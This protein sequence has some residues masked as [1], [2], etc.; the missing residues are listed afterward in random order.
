MAA[1]ERKLMQIGFAALMARKLAP[2]KQYLYEKIGEGGFV[3]EPVLRNN[4]A[5]LDDYEYM[6]KKYYSQIVY[7]AAQAG[8]LDTSIEESNIDIKAARRLWAGRSGTGWQGTGKGGYM[9]SLDPGVGNPVRNEVDELLHMY[10]KYQGDKTQQLTQLSHEATYDLF[11]K[12]AEHSRKNNP[13]PSDMAFTNYVPSPKDMGIGSE[14]EL[15]WY[16]LP[17]TSGDVPP[18]NATPSEKK[19]WLTKALRQLPIQKWNN[20]KLKTQ[21]YTSYGKA[22]ADF[23][24][25]L[26]NS[27]HLEGDDYR[28]LT[29]LDSRGPRL[30]TTVGTGLDKT[31]VEVAE[32]SESF[33][34]TDAGMDRYLPDIEPDKPVIRK[35]PSLSGYDKSDQHIIMP[36]TYELG[37]APFGGEG[38]ALADTGIGIGADPQATV[39]K[40]LLTTIF[41]K[42][43]IE[44]IFPDS[45]TEYQKMRRNELNKYLMN[46][47]TGEGGK[48]LNQ[49]ERDEAAVAL[50]N[51]HE[52]KQFL[53]WMEN[54]VNMELEELN[55]LTA[56][57][58]AGKDWFKEDY[59]EFASHGK[60]A[61]GQLTLSDVSPGLKLSL[62]GYTPKKKMIYGP[63]GPIST[64]H[65]YLA[66]Q[67]GWGKAI[68]GQVQ[69]GG[70]LRGYD[71]K[72]EI[73]D[74]FLGDFEIFGEEYG[75]KA[76]QI[77]SWIKNPQGDDVTQWE[78]EHGKW[79]FK[80][81]DKLSRGKDIYFPLKTPEGEPGLVKI[82]VRATV[83][84]DNRTSPISKK[85]YGVT[86]ATRP[87][88]THVK[89]TLSDVQYIKDIKHTV[90][91][92]E[93]KWFRHAEG[94]IAWNAYISSLY[95]HGAG[96]IYQGGALMVHSGVGAQMFM[97]DR[98][99]AN[100]VGFFTS[101]ISTGDFAEKL[102]EL[103]DIGAKSWFKEADGFGAYFDLS[104]MAGG[105]FK[106]WAQVWNGESSKIER[107]INKKIQTKWALWL[108]QYAGGGATAP[109]PR[110]AKS[111][112][113]PI[114]LGPFVHSTKFLGQAQSAT[115]RPHGYYT[116]GGKRDGSFDKW[117]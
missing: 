21:F 84:K 23:A 117:T 4:T 41:E 44:D 100:S 107:A 26:A 87:V 60:Y 73:M 31:S 55:A 10:L 39:D 78:Q 40:K 89:L 108:D 13:N 103:V 96:G 105:A 58:Y 49:K 38:G 17:Q 15:Q 112:E 3:F 65:R 7:E 19:E 83:Q 116:R 82:T 57:N 33:K 5:E 37:G 99:P 42:R 91:Q 47:T 62:S 59:P 25:K 53:M 106:E 115:M 52:V 101:T 64:A 97:G 56:G 30:H 69:S 92:E 102:K 70:W 48:S 9:E 36:F 12:V 54:Q 32:Y 77:W 66:G 80:W 8:E 88:R 98:T 81:N 75:Y 16:L 14:Q 74:G 111:W 50:D 61:T 113:G 1:D 22:H 94:V 93:V 18:S 68:E 45:F 20:P 110:V 43:K 86:T 46:F 6:K 24:V 27:E 2:L 63:E 11:D 71:Y 35:H 114:K 76:D 95:T 79:D 29:Q 85:K 72:Q 34:Q 28:R 109:P 51:I 90:E 67:S 104:E